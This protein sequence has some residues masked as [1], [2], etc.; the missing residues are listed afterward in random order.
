MGNVLQ[1]TS[2]SSPCFDLDLS[3]LSSGMYLLKVWTEDGKTMYKK[4]IKQ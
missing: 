4:V 1:E 3:R 2:A